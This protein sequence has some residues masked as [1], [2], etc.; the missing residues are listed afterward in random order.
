MFR[1]LRSVGC[2]TVLATAL[3]ASCLGAPGPVERLSLLRELVQ[4][5][6]PRVRV[7]ALRALA[8]I[9][10]AESAA[11]ALSALEKPM[12]PTLDYAL[13][14]T[15]NDLAEPWLAALQSGAWDP[16]GREQQLAFAL[17][18]LQPHHVNRILSSVL[19]GQRLPADG[20]GPWI[21][22]VGV[23][24]G[25]AELRRLLDQ[26]VEDGFNPDATARGLRA[27]IEAARLRKVRPSGDLAVLAKFLR[28][29]DE[30]IRLEAIRL[31]GL[32]KD[33]GS[34]LQVLLNEV[35]ARPE[36]SPV[37]RAAAFD[38]LRLIGGEGVVRAL[39]D[40]SQDPQILSEV[41]RE[42]AVALAG[43]DSTAGFSAV[44]SV[45]SQ[46]PDEST[47]LE[48]W[49][50]ILAIKGAGA[51]LGQALAERKLPE[52]V[53]RAGMRSAREGGRDEVELVTAFAWAGGLPID[54]ERLTADLLKEIAARAGTM[55]DAGRGERVYRRNE[56]AC[57][58][59]HA[60]GGAG[61]KA[62]PD[63]TSLGASAPMDYLVESLLLPSAR[64]KEGYHA[65]IVE[66]RDGEEVTGTL[67]RETPQE[68]FLRDSTG[69]EVALA[70]ANILHRDT[71]R[72]S[73]MPVGLLEPLSEPERLDLIAFLGQLGKPGPYDAS[74]GGV[75][76]RWRIAH[77]VHTDVQN[78][79][80]DWFLDR[81]LN[82]PRWV[83]VYTLVN[84]ELPV[85]ALEEA[86]KA[87]PWTSKV[88]VVL[89]TEV[90]VAVEG[91]VRFQLRPSNAELWVDRKSL[92]TGSEI[93][94]ALPAGRH[95]LVLRLD[96]RRLPDAVRLE[97]E[98]AM[99]TLD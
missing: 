33:I 93:T 98:G 61:G 91:P 49:R 41:R 76:R 29:A 68:L 74:K 14:L 15:I 8:R 9:P 5:D 20:A 97:G 66:T 13:W 90:T 38:A 34:A 39:R 67:A 6:S 25:P 24:G 69:K 4:D 80:A 44:V 12:D 71:S 51:S 75:A 45:A 79:E 48:F 40:W 27:M 55:G 73:L 95:R 23:A 18:A 28:N 92:G 70:K 78:N 46:L 19:G 81:P 31:A 53:A 84:G 65:V 47:A 94:V 83:P 11:I 58:T 43:I 50:R 85:D 64:I 62:G 26:A 87:Q 63:M 36:S 3:S 72:L 16:E 57:L 56:L 21:E 10:T 30:G 88:A 35:A 17:K 54:T 59:C 96:P 86:V 7:E 2:L 82:D 52:S 22:A 37:A 60:I 32:W 89:A 1:M 77:V 42:A 99:F